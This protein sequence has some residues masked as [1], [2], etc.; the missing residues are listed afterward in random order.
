MSEAS[1]ARV[2]TDADLIAAASP[3]YTER[4]FVQQNIIYNN[5]LYAHS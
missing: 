4:T 5:L 3:S 2:P 1:A